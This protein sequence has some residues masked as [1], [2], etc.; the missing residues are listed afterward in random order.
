MF[1]RVPSK[2]EPYSGSEPF[3]Q[4]LPLEKSRDAA[5]A[6][7]LSC[8]FDDPAFVYLLAYPGL[9]HSFSALGQGGLLA[10]ERA[11]LPEQPPVEGLGVRKEVERLSFIQVPE[12]KALEEAKQQQHRKIE[13]SEATAP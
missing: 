13:I 6:L 1:S 11:A 8:Y 7:K 9:K 10:G 2:I 12:I 4:P 5:K 3:F